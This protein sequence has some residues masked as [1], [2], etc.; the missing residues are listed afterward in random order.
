MAFVPA[1]MGSCRRKADQ[2]HKCHNNAPAVATGIARGWQAQA[3]W[4]LQD[5][6]ESVPEEV[7]RYSMLQRFPSW[8]ANPPPFHPSCLNARLGLRCHMRPDVDSREVGQQGPQRSTIPTASPH[9][10]WT[11][12]RSEQPLLQ[13]KPWYPRGEGYSF[14]VVQLQ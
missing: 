9:V 2:T 7:W 12:S 3:A 6:P 1:I 5:S 10:T 13:Y 11:R 14:C 8:G 4:R